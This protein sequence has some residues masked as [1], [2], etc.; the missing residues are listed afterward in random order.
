MLAVNAWDEPKSVLSRFVRKQKLN[1]TVLL[2]G[3]EVAKRYHTKG[4][5]PVV[6]WID[7]DGVVV[8]TE[9]G[10]EGPESLQRE[11]DRLLAGG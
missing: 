8:G 1:Q 5:V 2:N 3:S 9:F 7:R 4:S 11:T 6:L 10:Y